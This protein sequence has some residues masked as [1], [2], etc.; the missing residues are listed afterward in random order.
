MGGMRGWGLELSRGRGYMY[1]YSRF[2][3]VLQQKT[4]QHCKEII[5]QL[6][7]VLLKTEEVK[8]HILTY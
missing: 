2:I 8:V 5:L 4:T 3:V 1:I 6:K 7:I